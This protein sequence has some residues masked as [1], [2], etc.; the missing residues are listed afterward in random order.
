M[1]QKVDL[2]YSQ[3]AS[4]ADMSIEAIIQSQRYHKN[5]DQ[6]LF[7]M[8]AEEGLDIDEAA[9]QKMKHI[10]KPLGLNVDATVRS[11]LFPPK[12]PVRA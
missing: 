10:V 8:K 7:R 4:L 1:Q 2:F 6:L 12:G 5:R 3:E 11:E 9:L